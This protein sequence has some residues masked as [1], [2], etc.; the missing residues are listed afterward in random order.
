MRIQCLDCKAVLEVDNEDDIKKNHWH[1]INDNLY[2]CQHCDVTM[3]DNV[4]RK[5]KIDDA[6][7]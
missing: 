4:T 7:I 6:K 3:I 1:K 5:A 2:C